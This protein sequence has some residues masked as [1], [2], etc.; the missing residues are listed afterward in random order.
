M[1]SQLPVYHYLDIGRLGRGEVVYLFLKDAGIEFKEVRY[2]YDDTWPATSEKLQEKG[3]TRTGKVPSLEY[4]GLFLTQHIPTLR[5]LA[6]EL[7]QYDGET[8]LEKY[9]VDAVADVY[10]DWR[11]NWVANLKGVTKE[12][13]DDFVP[14]YYDVITKYYSEK[15][16]PY[17]LGDKI[18]YVDFAVYQSLDNDKRIGSSP[19]KLSAPLLKLKEAIEARPKI[20]AYLKENRIAEA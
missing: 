11:Y 17:L 16:G 10:I 12:F 9:T 14:W 6:R 1:A 5:Y 2:A 15:D 13:K 18:T 8:S 19:A 3:I 20:A 7:G 4:N